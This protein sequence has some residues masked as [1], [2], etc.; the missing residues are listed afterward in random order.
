MIDKTPDFHNVSITVAYLT[1]IRRNFTVLYAAFDNVLN[2]Q[3]TFGYIYSQDGNQRV[4]VQPNQ[5][6]S[7]FVGMNITFSK[8]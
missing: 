8:K 6:R 7:V 5:F 2:R 1:H 4:G 3:N